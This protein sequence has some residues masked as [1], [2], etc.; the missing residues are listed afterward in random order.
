M[1]TS[2]DSD[3]NSHDMMRRSR[4]TLDPQLHLR[5]KIAAARAGLS[6][7]E[8]LERVLR[9]NVPILPQYALPERHP[10]SPDVLQMLRRAPEEVSGGRILPDSTELIRQMRDGGSL[11]PSR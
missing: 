3:V 8:Y 2:S 6:M 7:R 9:E 5:I 4:L 1:T 10:I 11:S